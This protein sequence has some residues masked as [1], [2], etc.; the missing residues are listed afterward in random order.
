MNRLFRLILLLPLLPPL[1]LAAQEPSLPDSTGR[2]ALHAEMVAQRLVEAGFANVRAVQTPEF[3]VFTVEND[4]YKIP[5]EGFARAV[6]IIEGGGLDEDRPVKII[7][8][9]YKV[10]EITLTYDPRTGRWDATKRLDA[11]WDAVRGQ[12]KLND[13]FGKLDINVYPQVSLKNLIIT[14]VYQSL[15][16]LSP[17]FEVSLWPGGKISAQIKIPVVNDGYGISESLVHP[18]FL[19]VSQRFRD[20]WHLNVF[21][22]VTA[23]IFNANRIGAALELAYWFPNERFWVDTKMGYLDMVRFGYSNTMVDGVR[24][25][26]PAGIPPGFWLHTNA[27]P[28]WRFVWNLAVNYYNPSLQ[29]QFLLRGERFL[30]GDFGV[31]FEMIRHFRHCSVGFYAMKG[32]DK[33]A[34]SNGG[35]RFQIALPPYRAK[36]Y[37]YLPRISTSGQMGISYNANNEQYYYKEFRTEAA[38][39]IM[40]KNYYNPYYIKGKL[41]R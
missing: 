12:P 41:D 20:P 5:A 2:G 31:K 32:T 35:F 18:G 9:S 15:W 36:R 8:T 13:S 14:Q 10:P 23:G 1:A 24:P 37:G 25:D 28:D 16:Q 27:N 34:H 30:L 40:S 38:D 11:S 7:G 22:K 29:T 33:A 26:P 17:A 21:G 3:T 19:T 4:Y 39:N 6:Q